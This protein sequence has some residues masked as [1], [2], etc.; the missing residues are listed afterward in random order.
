MVSILDRLDKDIRS[1]K[2]IMP[3]DIKSAHDH[4]V[5]KLHEKQNKERFERELKKA[6]EDEAEFKELKGKFFGVSITE[7]EITISVLESVRD[8]ILEG[9][10]LCHCVGQGGYALRENSLILSAVVNGVKTETIEINLNNMTIAQCRGLQNQNSEYHDK[11]VDLMKR[12][13]HII[14][15]RLT[16]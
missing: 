8:H 1:P 10:A 5:K 16:A 11:I 12:N 9:E 3:T 14:K 6:I 13:I 4:W 15:K 7:N 2:Y